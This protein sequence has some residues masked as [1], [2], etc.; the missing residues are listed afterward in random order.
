M[1]PA[2][3]ALVGMGFLGALAVQWGSQPCQSDPAGCAIQRGYEGMVIWVAAAPLAVGIV[4][5]ITW[6][7][8]AWQDASLKVR[9]GALITIVL[10]ICFLGVISIF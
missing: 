6:R 1:I 3:V 2:L 8:V 7:V 5:A 4:S 9:L 10:L